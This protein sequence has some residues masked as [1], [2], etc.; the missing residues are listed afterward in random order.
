MNAQAGLELDRPV[1]ECGAAVTGSV[2]WSGNRGGRSVAVVLRY[3]TQGR[4]DTDSA[5]VTRA[6]LGT[7]DSGQS[8]FRLDVPLTGPVSYH[9]KLVQVLWE[10]AVQIPAGRGQV[11]TAD[12][13]VAP[14]GWSR[15]RP[16]G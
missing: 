5:V 6:D 1:V 13:S 4:G 3:R 9:G 15:L 2:R 8:P 14:R 10:V 12:V 11:V 7:A 16:D